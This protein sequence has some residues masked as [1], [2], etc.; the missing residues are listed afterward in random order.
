M[1]QAKNVLQQ[2]AQRKLET[3]DVLAEQYHIAF[4]EGDHPEM[5]RLVA[6]SEGKPGVEDCMAAEKAHAL[7]YS[8]QLRMARKMSMGAVNM[9]VQMGDRERAAEYQMEAAVREALLG[10][11]L[12]AKRSAMA[13]LN[14]S[15]GRDVVY[16]AAFALA[17]AGG[18]SAS[19]ALANDLDKRFPEDTLVRFNYLPTLRA[20]Y[21]LDNG[22]PSKAVELLQAASPYEMGFSA[23]SVVFLGALY[24]VYVRGDAYLANHREADAAAE[25]Q[26]IIDHRGIVLSDPIGALAYLQLGRAYALAG[27]T[28]KAKASYRGFLELW[29]NADPDIPVLRE[30]KSEYLKLR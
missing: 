24:P 26:K 8:G 14:L 2:A 27:D 11:V 15:K 6:Q 9:A 23:D 1:A 19:E 17:K 25:F 12:E 21:A 3:P 16:G 20:L 5:E 13:G 28:Q 4:L 22:R 29:K 10:N 7:A 30:A 18:S